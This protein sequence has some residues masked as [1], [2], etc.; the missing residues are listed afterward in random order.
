MNIVTNLDGP[1]PA[2]HYVHEFHRVFGLPID[3]EPVQS[4]RETRFDLIEEESYEATS[5]LL[6]SD[7]YWNAES[8]VELRWRTDPVR[9][10]ERLAK[11]LADLLYV[12]YGAAVEIGIDLDEAV[13]R[14]HRSN[15]SKLLDDGTPLFGP[16]GKVLKGPNYREP[17]MT[18]VAG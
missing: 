12:G 4:L 1:S 18:G 10:K 2:Y 3:A 13:R 11:E 9:Q 5:E 14:V 16:N 7:E 6:D 8:A 15:M 17:D